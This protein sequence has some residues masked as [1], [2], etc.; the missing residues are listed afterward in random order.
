MKHKPQSFWLTPKGI[1]SLGLIGAVSYFLLVEH[2]QHLFEFLPFLILLACPVMHIFMHR[3]RGH[4][5]SGEHHHD[6]AAESFGQQTDK[7][8]AYRDG[9]LEGLKTARDER[10]K[11]ESDDAR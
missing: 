11:K 2:R 6:D 4:Q 10:K 7:N 3:G 1:A 9:Y 5:H 8:K